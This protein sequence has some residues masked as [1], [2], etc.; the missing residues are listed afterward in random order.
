M[1]KQSAHTHRPS[2]ALVAPRLAAKGCH[3][4][5]KGPCCAQQATGNLAVVMRADRCGDIVSKQSTGSFI[6]ACRR[7]LVRPDLNAL[8]VCAIPY[9]Q[10]LMVEH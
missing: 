10:C 1:S 9:A 3:S 7:A 4:L 5:S 6:E 2:S 8:P